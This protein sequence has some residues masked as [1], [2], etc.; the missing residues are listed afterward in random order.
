MT[1][2]ETRSKISSCTSE[3]LKR[4]ASESDWARADAM[5]DDE[6]DAA[7]AAD[8]DE[9]GLDEAWMEKAV[10]T[11]PNQKQR[12]FTHLDAYV[13][14]YFKKGGRGY[15]TRMNEVLKAYVDAQLAK[16]SRQS[17]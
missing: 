4:T 8:P 3:D 7:V 2:P 15:Q 6:I 1:K 13:V 14:E 12:V 5:T 17:R 11:R 10:V 16:E 9:A